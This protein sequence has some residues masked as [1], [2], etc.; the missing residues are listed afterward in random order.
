MTNP[1]ADE[2][3]HDRDS[4]GILWSR[5]TLHP[6]RG[7]PEYG[8]V[9]PG[10]Q[11][12]AM[13]R[14][15]CQVCG[16]PA[17]QNEAGTLWLLKN[18]HTDWPAWPE[19]MAATHPPICTPCADLAPRLCPHLREDHVLIRVRDC[20]ALA[21]YGALYRPAPLGPEPVNDVTVTPDDPRARW[22]LAAQLVRALR[23]CTT[24]PFT[25]RE[26]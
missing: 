9:H 24:E 17:D 5:M 7:R 23:G 8:R 22:I 2:L 10:R 15:L 6:G 3:P 26:V 12:R 21:I 25:R 20:S 14:L 1:S 19:D 13:Q 18:D 16:K 4:H 11:R